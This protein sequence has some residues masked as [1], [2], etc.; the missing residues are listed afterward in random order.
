MKVKVKGKER[1]SVSLL[2]VERP[3]QH[4]S[5]QVKRVS[6]SRSSGSSGQTDGRAQD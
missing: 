1:E 3:V 6:A 4:S 5:T 2:L